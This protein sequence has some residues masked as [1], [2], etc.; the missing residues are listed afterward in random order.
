VLDDVRRERIRLSNG[1]V[2]IS[3]LDWGGEG[4]PALLHHANGFCAAV[5]GPVADRLRH[6]FRVFAMDARGH[7][8]SS[9]PTDPAAYH[10]SN[11]GLDA[12]GVA[13][14]LSERHG[15]LALGL[16]HSFGGTALVL[17]AIE[18][19]ALFER[20]VLLDPIILP[21]DPEMRARIGR[22]NS[23]AEGARRRRSIW[24]SRSSVLDSWADRDTFA[25]WKRRALELYVGFGFAERPD[26]RV[27]LCCPREA[28]AAIFDQNGSVDVMGLLPRLETPTLV[29]WARRGDF[30]R[31]HFEQL[32][33]RMPRGLLR[34]AD[35]GHFVPMEAPAFVAEQVLDFCTPGGA[36]SELQRSAG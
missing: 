22:G 27:E 14:V 15:P 12:L 28:E 35:T 5:W 10:W 31:E 18:R 8:G 24:E 23:L 13:E 30:P 11:F 36:G 29:L 9:K 17:A 20:L 26:G 6:R 34:E 21:S 16:G 1:A 2:E 33:A 32:A 4:P 7:G 3:L 25:G 19:P